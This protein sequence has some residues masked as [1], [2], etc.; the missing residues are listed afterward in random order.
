MATTPTRTGETYD[1]FTE[2]FAF[3]NRVLFNNQLPDVIITMQRSKRSRGY[4]AF[5]R[6]VHR[7][8]LARTEDEIALN[9]RA[10]IGRSDC[11][12]ISTLVH[13]MAHL[14]QF[15]FG[16]PSR[17]GYH[18]KEW[19]AKMAG[20]RPGSNATG[21]PGGRRTGQHVTHYIQKDGAYETNWKRLIADGFILNYQDRDV[22]EGERQEGPPAIFL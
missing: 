16:N 7:T 21:E 15:R 18:N 6:F 9:P 5:E 8:D 14:W 17:R 1:S 20:D 12:V 3:F 19:A 10:F 2:A 22:R 13:E 4:F 11:E